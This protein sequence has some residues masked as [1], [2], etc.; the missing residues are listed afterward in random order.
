MTTAFA[1][2]GRSLIM[3]LALAVGLAGLPAA[4]D[5]GVR[6]K[7]GSGGRVLTIVGD[8]GAN[9]VAV[10]L[11]VVAEAIAVSAGQ[12]PIASFP[13]RGVES[14]RV[15]LAGGADTLSVALTS[16]GRLGVVKVD[17]NLGGGDDFAFLG[18]DPAVVLEVSGGAGDDTVSGYRSG[19]GYRSVE[20]VFQS[21]AQIN[22]GGGLGFRCSGGTCTC[23]K[24]IENDCED[25]S[26]VCT[27]ASIDAL[28]GCI[29]GWLT[30]H[31]TCTKALVVTNPGTIFLPPGGGVL[32]R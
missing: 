9:E 18:V 23:D 13:A 27:D 30:T 1:S 25:M 12:V 11:D 5:A 7:S 10:T 2:K 3:G 6:A 28:I 16:G 19:E 8:G 21:T 31:C 26:G 4:A 14:V 17:V 24:S 15:R 20:H 29:Q 32:E 22:N